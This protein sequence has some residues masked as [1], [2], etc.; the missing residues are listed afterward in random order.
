MKPGKEAPP[1]P[2]DEPEGMGPEGDQDEGLNLDDQSSALAPEGE[3]P[4]DPKAG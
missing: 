4:V 3:A 1:S 2:D